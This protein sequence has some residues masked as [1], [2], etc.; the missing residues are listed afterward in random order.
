MSNIPYKLSLPTSI[1]PQIGFRSND[2]VVFKL[3]VTQGTQCR[4]G[5]VR[6]NGMLQLLKLNGNGEAIPI[7]EADKVYLNPNAGVSGCIRQINW[8]FNA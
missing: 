8:R 5:S 2:R 3:P 7:V 1:E 6:L 4:K